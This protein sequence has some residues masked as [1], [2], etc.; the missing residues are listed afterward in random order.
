M[1][2]KEVTSSPAPSLRCK[3]SSPYSLG[4]V[5]FLK[6]T[7]FF[8]TLHLFQSILGHRL[9]KQVNAK[10]TVCNKI[11]T[12]AH[13]SYYS[14]SPCYANL[15]KAVKIISKGNLCYEVRERSIVKSS[16][17]KHH[18]LYFFLSFCP[19]TKH[20]FSR[21]IYIVHWIMC[22]LFFN[23][24]ASFFEELVNTT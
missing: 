9:L 20:P 5:I 8:S 13:W 15:R 21:Y 18:S 16:S 4:L 6:K 1:I 12:C 3:G 22:C 17:H 23:L 7:M 11:Y 19:L 24:L 10:N 14:L 2:L